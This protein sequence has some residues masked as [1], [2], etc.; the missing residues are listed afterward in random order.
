MLKNQ[1]KIR[2]AN[3]SDR[4]IYYKCLSDKRWRI[5]FGLDFP[6]EKLNEYVDS[7]APLNSYE[8][9]CFILELN[10]K[11]IGFVNLLNCG[12]GIITLSGG[13]LPDKLNKGLGLTY[14]AH[15]IK[16]AMSLAHTKKISTFTMKSNLPS[17][18]MH[19]ALGFKVD[20]EIQDANKIFFT[21]TK[22]DF[23]N[24]SNSSFF[25]KILNRTSCEVSN[26]K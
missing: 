17:I 14:Y 11:S 8:L 3:A 26:E 18:R 20:A 9:D 13:L 4:T 21:L 16:Y 25:M 12:N 15:T 19:K 6:Q 2:N 1:I 5:L 24:F 23:R 10:S 22:E 7:F